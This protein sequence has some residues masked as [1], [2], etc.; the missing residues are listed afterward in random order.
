MQ[1]VDIVVLFSALC[2]LDLLGVVIQQALLTSSVHQNNCSL[3]CM[4]N[5]TKASVMQLI[6]I[7]LLYKLLLKLKSTVKI[8]P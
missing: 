5:P 1:F 7:T 2:M 4:K 8:L 6:S 3:E